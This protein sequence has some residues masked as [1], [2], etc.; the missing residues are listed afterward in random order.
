MVREK[1][2]ASCFN[3]GVYIPHGI[4][5][6]VARQQG[7]RVVNWNPAYRE[8]FVFGH[9]DAYHHTLMD[10]PTSEWES[11]PWSREREAEL[12]AYLGAAGAARRTGSLS[13]PI[14]RT[15]RAQSRA[16]SA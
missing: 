8:S 3:H 11:L 5:G 16:N 12:I 13:T 6:E 10:E 4:I 2:E 1:F 9:G 7:V 14:P 15:A